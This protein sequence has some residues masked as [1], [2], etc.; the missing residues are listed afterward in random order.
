MTEDEELRI[1]RGWVDYMREVQARLDPDNPQP[2]IFHWAHAE[3]TQLENSYNSARKRHGE[4]A[5]WPRD[6][7]FY[8]FYRRVMEREPVAVKGSWGFGLKAVANAMHQHDMIKTNWADSPVD[9]L[10][11]MVGAWHCDTAAREKGTSM[12]D[13]PLMH[14]IAQYNQ[15]DCKAMMEIVRYLRKNH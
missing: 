5:D 8:D 13:E 11:A 7:N 9:G 12:A 10:G 1:I 14:E 3:K 4:H 2:R 15:V 6:L